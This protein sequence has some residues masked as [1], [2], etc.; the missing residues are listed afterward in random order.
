VGAGTGTQAFGW[1]G[2]IGT[3]SRILPDSLGGYVM[4][5]LVQTNYGVILSMGG[6][7]VGEE[8]DRYYLKNAVDDHGGDGSVVIV[9][10]T[11]APLSDRNLC[12]MARRAFLGI[13]RT[14]SSMANGSG[15]YAIAFSTSLSVR[16]TRERRKTVSTVSDLANDVMSPLFQA[17]SEATEEAVYNA[18][19]Q[20]VSVIGYDGHL[21]ER[22]SSAAVKRV[23]DRHDLD[24]RKL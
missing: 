23:I 6:A 13:A 8:L 12:R 10:A 15:D 11:D 20:A 19:L 5:V 22:I 1:K 7:P 14:G 18:M 21:L 17:V 3:S 2:G 24:N 9:I 16:R 4:G